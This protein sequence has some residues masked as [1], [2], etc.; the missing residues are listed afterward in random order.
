M[1]FRSVVP[2]TPL[3]KLARCQ[4]MA[5][6]A[7]INL[8]WAVLIDKPIKRIIIYANSVIRS[9]APQTQKSPIMK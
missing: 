9:T 4:G 7:F 6:S 1:N 3:S 2:K 5:L 8:K